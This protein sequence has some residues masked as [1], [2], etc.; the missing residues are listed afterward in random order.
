MPSQ[1]GNSLQES[2]NEIN[3]QIR[4]MFN[5]KKDDD[6]DG[7]EL[8]IILFFIQITNRFKKDTKL[9]FLI[10][11]FFCLFFLVFEKSKNR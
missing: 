4:E 9:D 3:E 1:K 6:D 8:Q 2:L 5:F 10:N 11:D 7:K